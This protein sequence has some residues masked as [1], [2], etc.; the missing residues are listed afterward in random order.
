LNKVGL[1]S[2]V[3][4]NFSREWLK[5]LYS[6]GWDTQGI[7][8]LPGN[9]STIDFFAFEDWN[10]HTEVQPLKIFSRLG[11]SCPQELIQYIP[12]FL[13]EEDVNQMP[14]IAIRTEDIPR[15]YQLARMVFIAPCHLISQ[16]TLSVALRRL[17]VS[18]MLLAPS[19]KIMLPQYLKDIQILLHDIDI[20]FFQEHLLRS[21]FREISLDIRQILEAVASF[22]AKIVLSQRGFDGITIYDSEA[23]RHSYIPFYPVELLNPVGS[24]HVFCGGF[25]SNW[26][27]TYDPIEST[28]RGCISASLSMEGMGALFFL[29]RNP[30]LAETRL[31]SLRNTYYSR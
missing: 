5:I 28:L 10:T 16:M 8:L 1:I 2:R 3:G 29:K 11:K 7:R 25:L 4:E 19:E 20:V 24:G 31:S 30:F 23:K 9:Q 26:R 22:G 15:A 18:T 14:D 27:S 17:G 21:L 6:L 12:P 13:G